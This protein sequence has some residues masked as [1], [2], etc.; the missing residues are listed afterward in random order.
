[1]YSAL[2]TSAPVVYSTSRIA[3]LVEAILAG[4]MAEQARKSWMK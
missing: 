1:M 2:V 4:M 3:T